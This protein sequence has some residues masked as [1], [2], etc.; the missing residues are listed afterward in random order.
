MSID[1]SPLRLARVRGEAADACPWAPREAWLPAGALA[2]LALRNAKE[3][4]KDRHRALPDDTFEFRG[5][6]P[7]V[8]LRRR[9]RTRRSDYPA[10]VSDSQSGRRP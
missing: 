4:R 9:A 7:E 1:S 2:D 3:H 8:V 10:Q 6:R 5:G